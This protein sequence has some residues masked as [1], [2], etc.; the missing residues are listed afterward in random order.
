[1]KEEDIDYFEYS[2]FSKI[3]KI[4]EGGFGVVHKAE[5]ND[6]KQV[7][8]K[9]L[10]ER[11]SS[12]IDENVIKNFIK[13]VIIVFYIHCIMYVIECIIK[14]MLLFLVKNPPQGWPS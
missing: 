3:E 14:N 2:E 8:L 6:N 1:M 5:I 9:C 4:G 13:E 7:A 11:K 10:I 12:E